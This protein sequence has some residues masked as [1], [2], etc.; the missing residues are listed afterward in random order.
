MK[1]RITFLGTGTSQGIP[2]IACECSVCA[3][4]DHRDKRLRSSI[5]VEANEKVIVVDTGP[6]FRQQM[7]QQKVMKVDAVVFTH[8]HKDHVAGLDDIRAFNFRLQQAID[9]YATKQVQKALR[10][11]F[12]YAFEDIRYP[13]VPELRLI[14]I[15]NKPFEVGGVPFIPVEVMH[16]HLPV[17]GF[18]IG[19]FTYIT[20]AKTIS[21]KEIEKIK[22]SKIL[23][24]NALRKSEH[25]S[26]FTLDEALELMKRIKPEKG[27]LTHISH[28]LGKHEEVTKELPHFVEIAY[29][30]LSIEMD[31]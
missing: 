15:E 28:L 27:Y 1:M 13:G 7:L 29:D 12:Y 26:H 6:D 20:D 24:L 5:L 8:E 9:I 22:G 4:Q 19:D 31:L 3:S 25:I 16:Y 18:R 17:F 21:E 2:V 10:R 23:V 30:G 11:E 14:D